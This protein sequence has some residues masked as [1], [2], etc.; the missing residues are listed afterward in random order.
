MS[1]PV[2]NEMVTKLEVSVSVSMN[3]V[4]TGPTISPSTASTKSVDPSENTDPVKSP[5]TDPVTVPSKFP[6]NFPSTASTSTEE[7]SANILAFKLSALS[8]PVIS[9]IPVMPTLPT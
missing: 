2:F 6:K 1:V 5:T 3:E 4:L 8:S 7:S 9:S